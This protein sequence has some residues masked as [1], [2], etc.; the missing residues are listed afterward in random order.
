MS[1]RFVSVRVNVQFTREFFLRM[2]FQYNEFADS[3]DFEPLL[4]YRIN[5][6]T[7]FYVGSGHRW[8]D[9]SNDFDG[10]GIEETDRQYFAKFQYLFHN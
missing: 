4:T 8:Q 10:F 7:V 3:Y 6:F 5:P 1:V 2:I 9:Y